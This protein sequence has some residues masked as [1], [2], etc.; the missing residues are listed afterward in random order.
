MSLRVTV[1][2]K[3]KSRWDGGEAKASP[4]WANKPLVVDPKRR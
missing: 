1:S 3:S 2:G 4:K